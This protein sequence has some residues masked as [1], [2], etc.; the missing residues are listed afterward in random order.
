M[1][2][3]M[4]SWNKA[5]LCDTSKIYVGTSMQAANLACRR[6]ISGSGLRVLYP[7]SISRT[8]REE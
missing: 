5:P 8:L 1:R 7:L 4:K 6:K 3:E 2:E